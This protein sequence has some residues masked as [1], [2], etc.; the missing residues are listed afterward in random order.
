MVTRVGKVDRRCVYAN[1]LILIQR[2]FGSMPRKRDTFTD[3]RWNRQMID[4]TYPTR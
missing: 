3:P 4:T 2:V 1:R